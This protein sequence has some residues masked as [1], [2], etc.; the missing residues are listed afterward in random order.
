VV[1]AGARATEDGQVVAWIE[2]EGAG[3]PAQ[4]AGSIFERYRRSA[5]EVE[6]EPGGLGLG[7]SI[8]KSIIDRHGG[9]IAAERTSENRTRFSISL[10]QDQ[11]A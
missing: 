10:P 11:P 7:L 5:D 6:P 8:V 2:D 9:A 3:L 1:R 4:A